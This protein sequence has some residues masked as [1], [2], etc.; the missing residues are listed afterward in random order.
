MPF[1]RDEFLAL[2]AA[3]NRAVWPTQL[4]LLAIAVTCVVAIVRGRPGATRGA[5]AGLA[6]LWLWMAVAY[7]WVYFTRINPMA[8]VFGAMFA[9]QAVAL[10]VAALRG[11]TR[12]VAPRLDRVLG[13]GLVGYALVIYPAIGQLSDHPW[14]SAP[15]F[16]LPCPTTIFTLGVL[17]A[18]TPRPRRRLAILPALWAGVGSFAPFAFGVWEDLGLTIAAVVVVVRLLVRR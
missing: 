13:L 10:A 14:P 4:V 16:G 1:T 9:A 12:H 11:P 5:L 3:Y 18:A 6:V 15:S 2:F 17:L 7:H 8:W